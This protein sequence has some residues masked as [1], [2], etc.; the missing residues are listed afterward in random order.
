[1]TFDRTIFIG[2]V[3][4]CIDE[5]V[6]LVTSLRLRPGKDRVV[7]LGDLV[8]KGPSS[9]ECVRYAMEV[10]ETLPGSIFLMGNHEIRWLKAEE[11]NQIPDLPEAAGVTGQQLAWMGRLP[12]F[13]RFPSIRCFAVH[14][15]IYPQF[16]RD[17]GGLDAPDAVWGQK[18]K[19]GNAAERLAYTRRVDPE[20]DYVHAEK[21]K[22]EMPMWGEVYDGREGHVFYG[23]TPRI[24]ID[25]YPHATGLDTGCVYGWAL[26]AAIVSQPAPAAFNLAWVPARKQYSVRP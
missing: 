3:H 17:F 22:G 26:T 6:K 10:E 8:D 16:Y 15:G 9:V 14:G 18:R 2:D 5:F 7:G 13:A 12:L 4:G 25:R 11:R 21:E 20:G 1:M 23:H 24:Q 19:R